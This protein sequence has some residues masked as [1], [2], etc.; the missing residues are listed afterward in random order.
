MMTKTYTTKARDI[1]R[2]WHLIDVDEQIL[3]RVAAKIAPL[4]MGKNK[5][6]YAP[7]LDLGD[8]VVVVNAEGFRVTGR[9]ETQKMYYRAS[10]ML[11][12]LKEETLGELRER[13][14]GEALRLAVRG[15]LPANR[16]RDSR[17]ERFHI[18]TGS[19]HPHQGQLSDS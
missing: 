8:H 9:K 19:E 3:G 16:L 17:M 18:Y 13:R 2:Q 6:N 15:M 12:H 14:P 1:D 4:L 10:Q 11:G 7:Y 5:P